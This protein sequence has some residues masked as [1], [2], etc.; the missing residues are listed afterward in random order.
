MHRIIVFGNGRQAEIIYI[1][2]THDSPFEVV[3][4]TVDQAYLKE[5]K[6]FGL[7]VVPFEQVDSIYPP[8][9]YKMSLHLGYRDVNRFRAT[10]YSQA[11]TKGY[12][13]ISYVSSHAVTWPGMVIGDNSFIGDNSVIC[14]FADIGSNIFI[15]PG[16]MV[17]HHCVIGDHCFLAAGTVLLGHVTVEPFCFLGANCII[18][19]GTTVRRECIIGAGSYIHKDTKEKGVYITKPAELMPKSSDE[20]NRLLTWDEDMGLTKSNRS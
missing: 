8:T 12:D 10:K 4:F 3:A 17:G 15:G 19:E 9:M 5:E 6:L 16:S 2:L 14:P 13:L 11:K 1:Y 20:W 7:P 18:K